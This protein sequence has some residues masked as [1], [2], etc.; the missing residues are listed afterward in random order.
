[1]GTPSLSA[2]PLLCVAA[3]EIAQASPVRTLHFTDRP[4]SK[5]Q[6]VLRLECVEA[7]IRTLELASTPD[8][9]T[10]SYI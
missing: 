4:F 2:P 10:L 6:L 3:A 1:M 9:K 5:M 8:A 7:L